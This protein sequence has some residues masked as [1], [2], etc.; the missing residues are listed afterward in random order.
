MNI[1]AESA[2]KVHDLERLGTEEQFSLP[3]KHGET[4]LQLKF[5]QRREGWP[6]KHAKEREKNIRKIYKRF[7][8]QSQL[9]G[10]VA[11][12]LSRA[13]SLVFTVNRNF[14]DMGGQTIHKAN[15]CFGFGVL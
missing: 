15:L 6:A 7:G 14:C 10:E 4:R 8:E 12:R 9:P 11:S 13:I 5:E 2:K 1:E 3:V